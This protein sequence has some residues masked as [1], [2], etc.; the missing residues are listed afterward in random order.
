M[1]IKDVDKI[2]EFVAGDG[3][4]IKELLS[5]KND[6]VFTSYSIALAKIDPGR[7]SIPHKLQFSS[8]V[9]I[10]IKGIGIIHIEE[11]AREVKP[12]NII[13]I[14]KRSLQFIENSG[15]EELIFYC[16]VDPPWKQEDEVVIV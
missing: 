8:E 10:I 2:E 7:K 13:Y 4:W 15:M 14:P 1:I 11:E 12:G 16:I 9:Y 6:P 3:T 5:P